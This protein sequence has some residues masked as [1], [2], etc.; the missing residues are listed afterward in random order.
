MYEFFM[1]LKQ[2]DGSFTVMKDGEVDVR[3]A[4]S[5]H[6]ARV[7]TCTHPHKLSTRSYSHADTYA[8]GEQRNLLSSSHGNA[9]QHDHSRT[10]PGPPVLHRFVPDIRRRVLQRQFPRLGTR[11]RG[12]RRDQG[13]RC[14]SPS[15]FFFHFILEFD[16]THECDGYF[17]RSFC[18]PS[19]TWRSSRRIHVLLNS[20]LGSHPPHPFPLLSPIYT[21]ASPSTDQPPLPDPVDLTYARLAHRTG[22]V[23][24]T[25]EQACG[26]VL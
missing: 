26:W 16:E 2:P 22:G 1:S 24:R 6:L 10:H 20:L 23:Q 17:P 12:E 14:V 11:Y 5:F 15:L 21:R 4:N 9:P 7:C 19:T 8:R 25:H 18:S 3:Y 13:C